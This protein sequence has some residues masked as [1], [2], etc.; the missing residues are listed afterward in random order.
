MFIVV[1]VLV[2]GVIFEGLFIVVII[3]LVIGMVW[4]VKCCVVI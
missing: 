2:V 4:M 3:I 1:I